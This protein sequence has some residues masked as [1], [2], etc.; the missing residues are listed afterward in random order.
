LIDPEKINE[1]ALMKIQKSDDPSMNGY[2]KDT[3]VGEMRNEYCRTIC[4][5]IVEVSVTH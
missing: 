3:S 1:E 4:S 5:E 2:L